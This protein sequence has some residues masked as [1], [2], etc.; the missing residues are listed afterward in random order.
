MIINRSKK[1]PPKAILTT[2]ITPTATVQQHQPI[3]K[4]VQVDYR[5]LVKRTRYDQIESELAKLR[6]RLAVLEE[7][8]GQQRRPKSPTK[9]VGTETT[10]FADLEDGNGINNQRLGQALVNIEDDLHRILYILLHQYE[11]S[12]SRRR[13]HRMGKTKNLAIQGPESSTSVAKET[14]NSKAEQNF[15]NLRKESRALSQPNLSHQHDQ[16]IAQISSSTAQI[17][18]PMSNQV[19]ANKTRSRSSERRQSAPPK[20]EN[21]RIFNCHYHISK[22]DVHWILGTVS[23]YY[24]Q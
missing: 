21:S 17:A 18:R 9:S 10:I 20:T 1:T 16:S 8:S 12:N 23:N 15:R 3:P 13:H 22:P 6:E 7:E 4:P 11:M 2:T 14:P 19:T 24:H 5:T